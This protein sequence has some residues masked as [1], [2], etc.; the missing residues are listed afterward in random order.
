MEGDVKMKKIIHGKF[1][2]DCDVCGDD[3]FYFLDSNAKYRYID[4]FVEIRHI[5]QL[6]SELEWEKYD[7]KDVVVTIEKEE[8]EYIPN[9]TYWKKFI[10]ETND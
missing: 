10:G 3:D 2:H 9:P 6:L 5:E 1:V 7:Y 4:R 8:S